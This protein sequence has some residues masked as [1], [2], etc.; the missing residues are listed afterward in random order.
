MHN[1]FILT[2]IHKQPQVGTHI[3][4]WPFNRGWLNALVLPLV[5]EFGF[6]LTCDSALACG[7]KD[8]LMKKT[9]KKKKYWLMQMFLQKMTDGLRCPLGLLKCCA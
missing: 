7:T 2:C 4:I 3:I 9:L 1:L 5:E 6:R 8:Q